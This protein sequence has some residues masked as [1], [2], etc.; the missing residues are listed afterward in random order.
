MGCWLVLE[1]SLSFLQLPP[2]TKVEQL[3]GYGSLEA[4]SGRCLQILL[5][6]WMVIH[7]SPVGREKGVGMME[8]VSC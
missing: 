3:L 8:L 2:T 1:G 4:G 7:S 6:A 5:A